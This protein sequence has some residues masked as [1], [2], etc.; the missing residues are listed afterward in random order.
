MK[1]II[2]LQV[3]LLCMF[4]PMVGNAQY[5]LITGNIIN[6]KTGIALENVNILESGSGIGTISNLSG[7]FSLML[8]PGN[9]EIVISHAG[10]QNYSKKFVFKNDTILSVSLVPVVNLKP[11]NKE[12]EPQKIADKIDR[13]R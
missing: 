4:F 12:T 6:E 3:Y 11:K 10:F 8:K 9:A 5:L 1:I 2:T 13:V 7:F